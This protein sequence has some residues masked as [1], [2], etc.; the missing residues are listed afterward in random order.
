VDMDHQPLC[1]SDLQASCFSEHDIPYILIHPWFPPYGL[2][3]CI[4]AHITVPIAIV[5]S[6]TTRV[7]FNNLRLFFLIC[8]FPVTILHNTPPCHC[9]MD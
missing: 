2:T 1:N 7:C 9:F 3:Q 4:T 5:W 8:W 6:F